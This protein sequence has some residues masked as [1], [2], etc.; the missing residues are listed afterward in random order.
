MHRVTEGTVG[1]IYNHKGTWFLSD[2]Q[3]GQLVAH[4]Q[5]LLGVGEEAGGRIALAGH[6]W[7]HCYLLDRGHS[8]ARQP[9]SSLKGP[10]CEQ[11]FSGPR[12]PD[13][14][15]QARYLHINLYP[16]LARPQEGQAAEPK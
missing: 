8:L 3:I 4:S 16:P 9:A 6:F 7:K 12:P 14:I 10:R 1:S 11:M 13:H 5:S 15:S 2:R